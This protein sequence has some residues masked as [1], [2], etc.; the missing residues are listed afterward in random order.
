MK[1]GLFILGG[2]ILVLSSWVSAQ[3]AKE[4]LVAQPR[5]MKDAL[6]P[7]FKAVDS[8]VVRNDTKIVSGRN[9]AMFGFNTPEVVVYLPRIDN[10]AYTIVTFDE[11]RLFDNKGASVLFEREG[12]GYNDDTFSSEIRLAKKEGEGLVTFARV[13]GSGRIKYPLEVKTRIVKKSSDGAKGPDITL[14]G[15]FVTY[16]DHNISDMVFLSTRLGPVRAYDVK[17]R[18]LEEHS[19]K[20]I[21]TQGDVTRQTLAFWGG[22]AEIQIDTVIRWTDIEFTYDLPPIKPLSEDYAGKPMSR[23][24]NLVETPGG[25][26]QKKLVKIVEAAKSDSKKAKSETVSTDV[27]SKDGGDTPVVF[28]PTDDK[29]MVKKDYAKGYFEVDGK[30]VLL[31]HA[32]VEMREDPFDKTKKALWVYLTD[33]PVPLGDWRE[34][35]MDLSYEGKLQFI[36]LNINQSKH[37]IGM[38]LETPLLKMGYVSS[39]GGHTFEDKK[40]GPSM[41][42]GL[43]FT[44]SREFQ[45]QKYSYRVTFRATLMEKTA[46]NELKSTEAST[47]VSKKTPSS[48]DTVAFSDDV[49]DRF[50]L[51]IMEGDMEAVRGFLDAGMSP[52]VQRP[53]LGHSSLFAAIL[54]KHEDM[55]LMLIEKGAD[56]NFR[57]DN[58]S[59]PLM[60]AAENCKSVRLVKALVASGADVN[61]RAKGGNTPIQSAGIH[62]CD[63]IAQILKKAGAK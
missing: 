28:K 61:A 49:V 57:D 10:S 37:I 9:T 7:V 25:I 11:P 13:K 4:E 50:F 40:F 45:N 62:R 6:E 23:P 24:P 47:Q 5:L 20:S 36:E 55:A 63:E 59:T 38:V 35:I 12:G 46:V 1:T 30:K 31:N 29:S 8:E 53:R 43:A 48:E 34:Q 54:A 32:Y 3:P 26:V 58:K 16:I 60:W 51:S 44:D 21:S 15:P 52:N 2:L 56:V 19:Y 39:A 14:D 42:E 27:R 17:G 18:R 41:I 22:I 33:R